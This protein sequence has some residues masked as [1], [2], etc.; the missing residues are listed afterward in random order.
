VSFFARRKARRKANSGLN[1]PDVSFGPLASVG[2]TFLYL[3]EIQQRHYREQ[4]L[5]ALI[6]WA[7]KRGRHE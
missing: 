3:Q 7:K 4:Q 6:D 2:P 1:L 5:R